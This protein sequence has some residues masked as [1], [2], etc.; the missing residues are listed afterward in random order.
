MAKTNTSEAI[1]KLAAEIGEN[2]YI[3][4]AKWHLYLREA[5]LHTPLAE[6]VYPMLQNNS[7]EESKVL[8]ILS[9][10]P[11]KIG[12]KREIPLADLIP[13]ASQ[14]NLMDILEEYQRKM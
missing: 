1:E 13:T 2:V 10:I 7:L 4:I 9:D 12:G 6:R 8:Q 11:V 14:V 5:H 3:D